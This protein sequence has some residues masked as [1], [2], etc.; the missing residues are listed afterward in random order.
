MVHHRIQKKRRNKLKSVD[1]FNINAAAVREAK[2]RGKNLDPKSDEQPFPR[3][4]LEIQ[5]L[6]KLY[7]EEVHKV[8]NRRPRNRIFAESLKAGFKRRNFEG[9]K[10][11]VNRVSTITTAEIK[12]QRMLAKYELAGRD[13]CEVE[14]DYKKME[15]EEVQRR[16][17]RK[18]TEYDGSRKSRKQSFNSKS[19]QNKK[20]FKVRDALVAFGK[21]TCRPP[22]LTEASTSATKLKKKMLRKDRYRELKK[23]R[24]A[25]EHNEMILDAKEVIPFGSRVDGPPQFAPAQR[26]QLDP[27]FVKAGNKALLLKSKL[28]AKNEG[29]EK[30]DAKGAMMRAQEIAAERARVIAAYRMLKKSRRN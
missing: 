11:L 30:D 18:A 29:G 26:R 3:R 27:L 7:E 9:A 24:Q 25:D 4:L 16:L 19:N 2:L 12:E 22:Q 1:P 23:A 17:K 10:Q 6:S 14:A 5:Q 21:R 13:M 28:E 15:D 8:K 20:R